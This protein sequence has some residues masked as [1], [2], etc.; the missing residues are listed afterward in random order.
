MYITGEF[1]WSMPLYQKK[2][3]C[4]TYIEINIEES[5]VNPQKDS[6]RTERIVAPF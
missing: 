1:L 4:L 6:T 3:H 2:L 5:V